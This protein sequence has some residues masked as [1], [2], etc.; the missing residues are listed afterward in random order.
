M[1]ANPEILA[2]GQLPNVKGTLYTA[3]TPTIIRLIAGAHVAG[4]TQNVVLYVKKAAGTSRVLPRAEL[5][6]NE[7]FE[8]EEVITLDTGDEIEGQSTDAASVD[9]TIFGVTIT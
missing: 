7:S 4:G 5:M 2:D 1:P 8:E 9:Y 3:A 6:T